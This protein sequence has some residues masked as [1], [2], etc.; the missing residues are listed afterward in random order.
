MRVFNTVRRS[1]AENLRTGA[2]HAGTVE[3]LPAI[4]I[5][6][7]CIRTIPMIRELVLADVVRMS[8][9]DDIKNEISGLS[10]RT[11]N[12]RFAIK[13]LNRI[14]AHQE[15]STTKRLVPGFQLAKIWHRQ[16]LGLG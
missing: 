1:P 8:K 5:G 15:M 12:L 9:E 2:R 16:T 13:G 4:R 7:N 14:L 6:R 11:I 3:P 10:M